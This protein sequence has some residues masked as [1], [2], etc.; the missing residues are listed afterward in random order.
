MLLSAVIIT[1]NEAAN[2]SRCLTTLQG[3]ADEVIVLDSFSTDN[4]VA[5]ATDMGARVFQQ[6]FEGYGKQKADAI[7]LASHDWILSIDADEALSP[8]LQDSLR[9]LK[10]QPK[11]EAYTLNRLTNYCG[12]WI[13]HGGWYPDKLLRLVNRQQARMKE[14]AVHEGFV[15]QPG[16]TVGFLKGDLLHYSFPTLS[17]HLKKIEQYAEI[18]A[19]FDV[20]RGKRVSLLKLWFGPKWVFVQTYLLKLGILDGYYGYLI[21]KNSAFA[22]FA[23]Y[24]RIREYARELPVG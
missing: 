18:G 10:K 1:L 9:T 7:A 6:K 23:K 12:K 17:A 16:V 24:A 5:I 22:A 4:T 19:R 8:A 15:L 20:A 2:I 14:D 21:A 13:R 11:A 3:V